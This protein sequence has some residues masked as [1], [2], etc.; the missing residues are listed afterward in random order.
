MKV[1]NAIGDTVDGRISNNLGWFKSL[2]N[3]GISTTNLNW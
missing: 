1:S 3:H 2:V